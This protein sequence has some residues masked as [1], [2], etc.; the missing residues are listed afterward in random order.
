MDYNG[1]NRYK[2]MVIEIDFI[3][4]KDRLYLNFIETEIEK[5]VYSINIHEDPVRKLY[6]L[7]NV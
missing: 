6:A 7:L 5:P 3:I 2:N 1:L 4:I